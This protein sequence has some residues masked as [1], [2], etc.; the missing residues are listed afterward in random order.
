MLGPLRRKITAVWVSGSLATLAMLG[1][2]Y[3]FVSAAATASMRHWYC[4]PSSLDHPQAA[5]RVGAKL[6]LA[7]YGAGALALALGL[8]TLWLYTRRLKGPN[9][10][11]KPTPL[12][13]AA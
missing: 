12:R 13:G 1:D 10:S 6:L 4:G 7:S 5:C 11:S 3:L 8:A 2:A 9:N